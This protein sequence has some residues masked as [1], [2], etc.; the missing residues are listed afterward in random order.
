MN[1]IIRFLYF[2]NLLISF[3]AVA[4]GAETL[5]L[6]EI[7]LDETWPQ[8][9]FLGLSTLGFYTLHD[10]YTKAGNK[11]EKGLYPKVVFWQK[12]GKYL[13]LPLPLAA[14]GM[15]VIALRSFRIHE[16]WVIA[17]I[18]I[19]TLL[20]TFPLLPF[21]H[22]RRWKN[23]PIS[24]ILVLALVWTAATT[25]LVSDKVLSAN[26]L[27]HIIARFVFLL[28]LCIPFDTRDA[29]FDR[30]KMQQTLLDW[31]GI[32]NLQKLIILLPALAMLALWLGNVQLSPVL[33]AAYM[34]HFA[35]TSWLC[36]YTLKH[37][38]KFDLYWLLDGQM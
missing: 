32:A 24:K 5:W 7:R 30:Q 23:H 27:P 11:P 25:L 35:I 13:V 26:F 34:V 9:I 1:R 29:I 3:A 12:H 37:P 14:I 36:H 38:L 19:F 33:L 31:P 18:S 22:L 8:L 15:A 10:Y 20:Y 2:S 28:M 4:L 21:R 16:L 17:L 6:L